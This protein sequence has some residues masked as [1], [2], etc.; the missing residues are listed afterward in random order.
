[1]VYLHPWEMDAEHPVVPLGW[2]ARLRHTLNTG[3]TEGRLRRLLAEFEFAP[4]AAILAGTGL[5][6]LGGPR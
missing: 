5:L 4:A 3:K 2:A 6:A 1:M